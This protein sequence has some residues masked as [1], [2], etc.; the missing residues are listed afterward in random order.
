MKELP[1]VFVNPLEKEVKN[2]KEMYYSKLIR[3]S[4]KRSIL[5]EIDRVFHSKDFVYKKKVE[6]T[7]HDGILVE[8]IIGKTRDYLLT[9]DGKKIYIA[10]IL[11]I[12]KL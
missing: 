1:K 9:Y 2:N 11:D 8:E 12:K 3:S 10:D 4:P 5:Q 6:I 7:T